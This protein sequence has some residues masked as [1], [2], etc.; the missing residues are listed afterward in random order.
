MTNLV[1]IDINT[2]AVVLNLF[3]AADPDIT[4]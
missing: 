1:C 3:H 2:R 4:S